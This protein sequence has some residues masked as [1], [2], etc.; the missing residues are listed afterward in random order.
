M[1]LSVGVAAALLS[2]FFT[3]LPDA[4]EL[5]LEVVYLLFEDLAVLVVAVALPDTTGV[6]LDEL[7]S[8]VVV[9]E[10]RLLDA[11]AFSVDVVSLLVDAE[12]LLLDVV[13][14]LLD[15]KDLQLDAVASPADGATL[16]VGVVV[17]E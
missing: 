11:A 5:F 4:D 16:L 14:L 9:G 8:L 12:P 3:L 6:S 7:V 15:C 2:G 13:F 10:E 17:F 1:S